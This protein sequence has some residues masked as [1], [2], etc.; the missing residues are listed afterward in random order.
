MYRFIASLIFVWLI[1]GP[2]STVTPDCY[3]DVFEH[4]D[5]IAHL[6]VEADGSI[7]WDIDALTNRTHHLE[8]RYWCDE[9]FYSSKVK[10]VIKKSVTEGTEEPSYDSYEKGRI[11]LKH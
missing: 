8:L 10:Y 9:G 4:G 11:N 3:Y 2:N 1:S 6:P 7:R 5:L